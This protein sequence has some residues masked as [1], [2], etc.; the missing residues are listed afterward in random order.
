MQ[1]IRR[2]LRLWVA[3]WLVVQMASLSALVPRDCC[4]AH[5]SAAR[6]AKPSCH[7]QVAATQCPMR[8]TDGTPCPMH[9]GGHGEAS[10]TTPDSCTMRGTC[11]GPMAALVAQLSNYG[12]LPAALQVPPDLHRGSVTVDS[13]EDLPSRFTPPDSPPPRA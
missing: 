6:A 3:I 1:S 12:V 8:A 10:E 2:S 5:S 7:E 9:R 11:S 13:D 4:A